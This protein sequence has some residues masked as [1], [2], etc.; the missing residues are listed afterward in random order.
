M[1]QVAPGR[2]ESRCRL[3]L[4]Q[5]GPGGDRSGRQEAEGPRP[6]RS[7]LPGARSARRVLR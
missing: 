5:R 4:R 2:E 7:G 3:R 1:C 6:G